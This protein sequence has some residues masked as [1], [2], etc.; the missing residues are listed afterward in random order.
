MSNHLLNP[1]PRVLSFYTRKIA[2]EY[3]VFSYLI[4]ELVEDNG[5]NRIGP[6]WK[7]CHTIGAPNTLLVRSCPSLNTLGKATL[8]IVRTGASRYEQEYKVEVFTTFFY[9]ILQH[10]Y[11]EYT[12]REYIPILQRSSHAIPVHP[13]EN[14]LNPSFV[15]GRYLYPVEP[16]AFIDE[17]LQHKLWDLEDLNRVQENH[18]RFIRP[19]YIPNNEIPRSLNEITPTRISLPAPHRPAPQQPSPHRP[20]PHRPIQIPNFVESFDLEDTKYDE[21]EKSAPIPIPS[22]IASILLQDAET[23][24]ETCPISLEPIQRKNSSVTSCYHMFRTNE[25]LQW[26][27]TSNLCPVCKSSMVFTSA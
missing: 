11:G 2:I 12:S 14:P 20:A 5:S 13:R 9:T 22:R 6:R 16:H 3:Y 25:L 17:P 23:K 27:Q 8:H 1:I 18:Q 26:N 19:S 7:P 21:T 4:L 24:N 15:H 10:K